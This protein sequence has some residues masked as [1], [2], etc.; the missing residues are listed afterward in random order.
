MLRRHITERNCTIALLLLFI[1]V[2]AYI[3]QFPHYFTDEGNNKRPT[4]PDEDAYYFW[5]LLYNR[6][7]YAVPIQDWYGG[8]GAFEFKVRENGTFAISLAITSLGFETDVEN[9]EVSV[10]LHNNSAT[11]DP[12][13]NAHVKINSEKGG[14]QEKITD[15]SGAATFKLPKGGNAIDAFYNLSGLNLHAFFFY[16][17]EKIGARYNFFTSPVY[18]GMNGNRSDL[19]IYSFDSFNL[20]IAG[21][22]VS[23]DQLVPNKPPSRPNAIGQTDAN[24]N[25]TLSGIK[26]GDYL[27]TVWKEPIT[28]NERVAWQSSAVKVDS[29]YYVVSMRAPGYSVLLGGF[30]SVG[31]ENYISIFLIAVA[32]ISTYLLA[33][34]LFDWKVACIASIILLTTGI[35][36]STAYLSGLA[37]YATMAFAILG[38]YLFIEAIHRPWRKGRWKM[39]P[40]FLLIL[41]GMMLGTSIAM[42][43]STASVCLAPFLYMFALLFMDSRK[44]RGSKGF[45]LTRKAALRFVARLL[46]F[47]IGI[48]VVGALVLNYNNTYF[49][50]PFA[51]GYSHGNRLSIASEGNNTS[52]GLEERSDIYRN[53][54]PIASSG[55]IPSLLFQ[56]LFMMPAI[57]LIPY[58]LISGRKNPA[59]IFL[60][61]VSLLNILLYL[62]VPWVGRTIEDLRYFLPA[63]PTAAIVAGYSIHRVFSRKDNRFYVALL[64]LA[65]LVGGNIASAHYVI[66]CEEL[67]RLEQTQLPSNQPTEYLKSDVGTLLSSP[68]AYDGKPVKVG[69][70]TVIS[71]NPMRKFFVKDSSCQRN[72]TL[73]IEK[74]MPLPKLGDRV[75]VQGFFRRGV[76]N[77]DGL[78][79]GEWELWIRPDSKD[80]VT[81]VA[82]H[83]VDSKASIGIEQAGMTV[84]ADDEGRPVTA[85]PKTASAESQVAQSQQ[86]QPPTAPGQEQKPPNPPPEPAQIA[87]LICAVIF[88]VGFYGYAVKDKIEVLRK[89]RERLD[90]CG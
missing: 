21:G 47:S 5:G 76:T 52:A 83:W 28:S 33:R 20:P 89:R 77:K 30:V 68:T 35:A 54:D 73:F 37:D 72:L 43:Y 6:G 18:V 32:T 53:F 71:V 26:A 49:G 7:K 17:S 78:Q 55:N 84:N 48:A 11:P 8:K 3:L 64:L 27:F 23:W 61:V 85:P 79:N 31:M 56:L 22:N 34:R 67:R 29:N 15:N 4:C 69:N 75:D 90:G 59:L 50:S 81:I 10:R 66:V 74:S 42:R 1:L 70:L 63:L 82:R 14:A 2:S 62:C 88:M 19:K 36:V 16:F 25:Y 38:I 44:E 87:A 51:S 40:H 86:P 9:I 46:L 39:V 41:S 13:G 12:C 24:G 60:V 45:R 57:F 65:I 80:T 58:G